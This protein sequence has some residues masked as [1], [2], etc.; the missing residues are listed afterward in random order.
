MFYTIEFSIFSCIY[1]LADMKFK[2]SSLDFKPYARCCQVQIC[3]NQ[4]QVIVAA[5]SAGA[6]CDNSCLTLI[7]LTIEQ[8]HFPAR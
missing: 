4:S 7:S 8:A 2:P 6:S 1:L 5:L 3:A